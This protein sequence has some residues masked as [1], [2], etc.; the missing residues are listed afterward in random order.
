MKKIIALLL[1]FMP[2]VSF[3]APQYETHDACLEDNGKRFCDGYFA[4]DDAQARPQQPEE[5]TE[6]QQQSYKPIDMFAGGNLGYASL[7][8]EYD[9]ESLYFPDAFF[10][11]GLEGGVKF[12]V[13]EIYS[14]GVVGFYDYMVSRN[15]EEWLALYYGADSVSVGY[16]LLG[17]SLDNYI[18]VKPKTHMVIG[19]GY[20]NLT[21]VKSIKKA[22]DS[23]DVV[24]DGVDAFLI[25]IG[26]VF[27]ITEHVSLTTSVKF[28][29]PSEDVN[30][31]TIFDI[32]IRF[33]F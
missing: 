18:R 20:A 6:K 3:A 19:F 30:F 14:L 13:S 7:A 16:S 33:V 29:L 1:A 10:K 12:N 5:K 11:L 8:Y 27:Q 22:G 4:R 26:D 32:G 31:S 21:T 25:K 9:S 15:T 28:L 23:A 24:R 2:A 17:A